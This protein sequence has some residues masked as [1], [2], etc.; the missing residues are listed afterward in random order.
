MMNICLSEATTLPAT[1]AEDVDACAAA[2]C[3]ALEVWL[4]KLEK[5]LE[6]SSAEDTRKLLADKGVTP[7]AASYQGGLLLSQGEA[8]K[9]HFDHFRRRPH[10]ARRR[11]PAAGGFT[12]EASAARLRWICLLGIDEPDAVADEGVTG[13]GTGGGGAAARAARRVAPPAGFVRQ[14]RLHRLLRVIMTTPRAW[15]A[16]G[17]TTRRSAAPPST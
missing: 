15:R 6:T 11:R 3:P 14:L 7:A 10:P 5:H 8:R 17:P 9:A 1:F 2:G 13:R 4:T 16:P 12:G